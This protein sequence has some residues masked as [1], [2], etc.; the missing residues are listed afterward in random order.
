MSVSD[1]MPAPATGRFLAAVHHFPLRVYFED[2][3]LSGL[4]Y[5]ANYLRYMERARSDMLRIAGIDQRANHEDGAGV[6]AV[7]DLAIRYRRP[8]RL[9]DDLMVASRVTDVRAASCA[10]HQRVMRGQEELTDAAITVAWLTPQGRPQRQ[11]KA[12]T[13]IFTRLCQGEDIHP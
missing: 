1:L 12:W 11:P 4:V 3:D 2:T 7:T 9:D 6:Y 10:I 5:H 8:A 13:E